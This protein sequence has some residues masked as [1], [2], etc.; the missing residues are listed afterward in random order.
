M[1][2]EY[3]ALTMK[4]DVIATKAYVLEYVEKLK[5]VIEITQNT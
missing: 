1:S 2:E 3:E 5:R 4:F